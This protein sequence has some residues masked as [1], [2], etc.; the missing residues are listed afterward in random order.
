M[1]VERRDMLTGF[2]IAPVAFRLLLLSR[3]GISDVDNNKDQIE[4]P[5]PS[6]HSFQRKTEDVLAHVIIELIVQCT[7]CLEVP[8]HDGHVP[9][10]VTVLVPS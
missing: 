2:R 3:A 10:R 6:I 9:T 7:I 8:V 5:V 1:V 4:A